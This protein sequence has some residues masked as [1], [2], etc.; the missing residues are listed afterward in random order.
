MII[1][2]KSVSISVPFSFHSSASAAAPAALQAEDPPAAWNPQTEQNQKATYSWTTDQIPESRGAHAGILSLGKTQ[3]STEK[4][5]PIKRINQEQ[6]I[7]I[8]LK[9][10]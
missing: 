3:I 5:P 10:R 7:Y 2:F 9:R 1:L 4:K 8:L 6:R